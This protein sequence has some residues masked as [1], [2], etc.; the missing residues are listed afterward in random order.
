MLLR[1]SCSAGHRVYQ[2]R[3]IDLRAA[4]HAQKWQQSAAYGDFSVKILRTMHPSR[5]AAA[6]PRA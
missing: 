5:L 3:P 6:L 4:G 1:E 2:V